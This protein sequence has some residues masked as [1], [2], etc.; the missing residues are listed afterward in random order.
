MADYCYFWTCKVMLKLVTFIFSAFFALT[1]LAHEYY[2]AFAEVAFDELSG[3][4]QIT[5]IA[6]SH[7]VEKSI[8]MGGERISLSAGK[9][10]DSL[11]LSVLEKELNKGIYFTS[12]NQRSNLRLEGFETQL[13]G[14]TLFYLSGSFKNDNGISAH[15]PML[16]DVFPE[17]QN[18]ITW[19]CRDKKQ[20]YVFL[21]AMTSQLISTTNENEK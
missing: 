17:Q 20:T 14:T 1:S 6:T 10:V 7:D 15:F 9:E 8:S 13:N 5:V 18:K 2:F 12:G 21:P 3:R 4:L 16:M 11:T 19:I